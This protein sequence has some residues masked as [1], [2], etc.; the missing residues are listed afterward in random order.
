MHDSDVG[1]TGYGMSPWLLASVNCNALYSILPGILH[2]HTTKGSFSV[3]MFYV[4]DI[5]LFLS[6]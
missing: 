5:V 1:L 3:R 6:L 2:L 4:F